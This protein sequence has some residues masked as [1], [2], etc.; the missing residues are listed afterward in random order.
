MNSDFQSRTSIV[1]LM[2]GL[3]LLL[4]LTSSVTHREYREKETNFSWGWGPPPS[5]IQVRGAYT[6]PAATPAV[7]EVAQGEAAVFVVNSEG[8]EEEEG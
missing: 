3:L 6:L 1:L 2:A 5:N 4:L 8:E 7:K